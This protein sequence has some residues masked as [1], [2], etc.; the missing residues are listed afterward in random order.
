M[1]VIVIVIGTFKSDCDSN[2]IVIPNVIRDCDCDSGFLKMNK[3][4]VTVINDS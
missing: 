4:T 2:V 1:I 3:M